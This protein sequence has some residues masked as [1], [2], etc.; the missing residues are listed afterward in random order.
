MAYTCN[1]ERNGAEIWRLKANRRNG[2]M[3]K[4]NRLSM[5]AKMTSIS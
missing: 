3:A 4:L 5:A 2:E 1:G